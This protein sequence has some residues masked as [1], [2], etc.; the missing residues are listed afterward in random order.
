MLTLRFLTV[1]VVFSICMDKQVW[2]M[3]VC[4]CV[5]ARA[6]ACVCVYVCVCVFPLSKN[7][8]KLVIKFTWVI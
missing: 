5:Y 2:C 4:V 1:S 3:C 7:K 8:C 6:R